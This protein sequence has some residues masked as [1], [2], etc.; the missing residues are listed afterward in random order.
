MTKKQK[1]RENLAKIHDEVDK[2]LEISTGYSKFYRRK[3]RMI[4]MKKGFTT[5]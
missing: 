3:N 2:R 1:K 5:K 4:E